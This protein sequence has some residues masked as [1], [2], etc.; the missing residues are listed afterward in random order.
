MRKFFVPLF[1]L[2][3]L[4]FNA[5]GQMPKDIMK[6]PIPVAMFQA[7]YAFHLPGLDN[8]VLYGISHNVG[9]SF[10]FKT[11]SNWLFSVNAN[12]IFGK[13]L[14]IDR[15]EIFGEGIT[16]DE[17]EII[18]G[19]GS[20]ATLEVNQRGFH[21]QGE[22]GKLFP[23]GPNPNSGFFVQTGIGYLRNRIRVDYPVNLLN[24][25]YQV[26]GDYQYGYDRM[27]GGPAVHLETGY[28]L[29]N[30]TRVLNLSVSF[31]V[32]YART[33]DLRDYDFRVFTNPETGLLEPVGPTD[34]KKRYNDLYYGIRVTWNIP[35]YQRQPDEYYYN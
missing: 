8:K 5:L 3:G 2:I 18:G 34:P 28:L 15:V 9:G 26:D 29:L 27:R 24:T 6:D 1:L 4:S 19:S 10:V 32:T 30:D 14:N 22:L 23:F 12:Y 25:P 33:H 21:F 35:T 20:F 13:K 11:E 31:E 16:T 7:T 17:G